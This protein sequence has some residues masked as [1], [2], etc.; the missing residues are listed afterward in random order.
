MTTNPSDLLTELNRFSTEDPSKDTKSLKK[1]VELSKRLVAYLSDPISSA[2]EL[3]LSMY[4]MYGLVC[5]ANPCRHYNSSHLL[6][7]L[8]VSP[9]TS[10]S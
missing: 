3:A 10:N 2:I 9:L 8:L 4:I 5:L 7:L 6:W 1:A